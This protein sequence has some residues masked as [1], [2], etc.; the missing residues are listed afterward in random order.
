[1]TVWTYAAWAFAA[2]ALIPVMAALS[3]S[4]GRTLGSPEWTPVILFAVA[5]LAALTFAIA[6]RHAPPF[7]AL[8]SARPEQLASGLI[9]F[10]YLISVTYLTPRFGVGPTVFC[11]VV[12]QILVSAAIGQFALFGAPRQVLDLPRLAGMALMIGG[13]MLFQMRRA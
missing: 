4:L 5:L 7:G 6:S 9:V 3:G 1:M 11:V 8:R 2:G 12:A 13:L 10:F